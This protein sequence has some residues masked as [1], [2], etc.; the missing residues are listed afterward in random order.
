MDRIFT[1]LF[2][3]ALVWNM[4]VSPV[5][6]QDRLVTETMAR[7]MEELKMEDM[8]AFLRQLD[9]DISMDLPVLEITKIFENLKSGQLSL[10]LLLFYK[11][12]PVYSLRVAG[13]FSLLGK[14]II[15]AI[16]AA[17]LQNIQAA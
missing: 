7:Q 15:L 1:T 13:K 5:Q 12:W 6:A 16:I 8:E 10:D 17:I 14:L 3:L 2:L 4:I 11:T 9:R